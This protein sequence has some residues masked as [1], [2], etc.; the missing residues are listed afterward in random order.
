[1]FKSDKC[2]ELTILGDAVNK[3]FVAS[4]IDILVIYVGLQ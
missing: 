4:G 2:L 1:M 3:D